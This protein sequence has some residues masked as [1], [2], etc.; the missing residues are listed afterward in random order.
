MQEM[1]LLKCESKMNMV[2]LEKN[3]VP[4]L[5]F[6][7]YNLYSYYI[8][9]SSA[10]QNYDTEIFSWPDNFRAHTGRGSTRFP[11]GLWNGLFADRSDVLRLCRK[12]GSPFEVTAKENA[13]SYLISF[14]YKWWQVKNRK[15]GRECFQNSLIYTRRKRPSSY[16]FLLVSKSQ[17]LKNWVTVGLKCPIPYLD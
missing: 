4:L 2:C 8:K 13:S 11:N 6:I 14:Q 17:G 1:L 3:H 5:R 16:W 15:D 10:N 12:S 9:A 7:S